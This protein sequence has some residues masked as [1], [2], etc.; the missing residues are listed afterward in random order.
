MREHPFA[1]GRRFTTDGPGRG[2][3]AGKDRLRP[4]HWR[5]GAGGPRR[6]WGVLHGASRRARLPHQPQ[7][8]GEAALG[9]RSNLLHG[10]H[11][12]PLALF[13]RGGGV[14]VRPLLGHLQRRR[15]HAGHGLGLGL[16]GAGRRWEVKIERHGQATLGA[17][18]GWAA[19][20]QVHDK[21]GVAGGGAARDVSLPTPL[22]VL[23]LL[24]LAQVLLP[25]QQL[26]QEV[27]VGGNGGALV[28]DIPAWRDS[29]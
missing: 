13:R 3:G 29:G 9:G 10:Q 22:L 6:D 4:Q 11:H 21:V 18:G 15:Q 14:G 7:T 8:E 12:F 28:L 20:L 23:L 16:D 26:S 24:L 17:G 25:L 2:V 19:Q 5:T 1:A 27:E